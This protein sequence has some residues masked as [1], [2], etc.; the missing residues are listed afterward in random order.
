MDTVIKF[1]IKTYGSA[2][3]PFYTVLAQWV[4]ALLSAVFLKVKIRKE[5]EP[6]KPGVCT[7]DFSADTVCSSS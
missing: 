1:D 7:K 4:G 5:H 3:A 2:M 6:G